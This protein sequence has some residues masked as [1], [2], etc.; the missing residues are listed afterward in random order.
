M[1][2]KNDIFY[3]IDVLT[4]S[5]KA[6][7]SKYLLRSNK[8]DSAYLKLFNY[9]CKAK[10]I[11]INDVRNEFK[12]TSISKNPAAAFYYLYEHILDTL[13]PIVEKNNLHLTSIQQFGHIQY[14]IRKAL[15]DQA[16]KK[17]I[18][19]KPILEEYEMY[20]LYIILLQ[21]E[22]NLF[23]YLKKSLEEKQWLIQKKIETIQLVQNENLA[24]LQV[25]NS[26]NLIF[27]SGVSTRKSEEE[28]IQEIKSVLNK[29]LKEQELSFKAKHY[30]YHALSNI[31]ILEH[32]YEEA[33]KNLSL[34]LQEYE[35]RPQFKIYLFE[36]Y[37]KL[38][39]N[40]INRLVSIEAFEKIEEI[41]IVIQEIKEIVIFNKVDKASLEDI[42]M[43]YYHAKYAYYLS[44]ENFNEAYKMTENMRQYSLP[45]DRNKALFI[46]YHYD[47]ACAAFYVQE[48]DIALQYI[49]KILSHENKNIFP[50]IFLFTRVLQLFIYYERGDSMAIYHLYETIRKHTQAVNYDTA[51]EKAFLK[52][53]LK[54]SDVVDKD[55]KISL[56]NKFNTTILSLKEKY[57]SAFMF[58]KVFWWIEKEINRLK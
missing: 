20:S 5:E 21:T 52:M 53:L 37:A 54:L 35:K 31:A 19:F 29:L 26:E 7:I 40:Y 22:I 47:Y 55:T 12:G 48:Y 10:N 50:D 58:F 32:N 36:N 34:I 57:P 16:L 45:M 51:V 30:I 2:V 33:A 28:S 25:C 56:L 18:L 13:S 46:I 39:C 49:D 11:E 42:Y 4:P 24:Q 43:T 3:L 27:N 17:I 38:V 8:K 41:E 1:K 44:L 14:L 15:Y 6:Y 23:A 9:L